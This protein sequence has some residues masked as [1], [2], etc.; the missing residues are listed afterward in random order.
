MVQD[1]FAGV[2]YCRGLF[3]QYRLIKK[4]MKKITGPFVFLI[5]VG[6]GAAICAQCNI[7]TGLSGTI[8]NSSGTES[9]S[10]SV[11][12]SGNCST[13]SHGSITLCA[14]A[15]P[16]NTGAPN[17]GPNVFYG[18]VMYTFSRPIKKVD[19][20]IAG[21]G[22]NQA[23]AFNESYS[24]DTNGSL[25]TLTVNPRNLNGLSVS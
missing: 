23:N 3:L 14:L 1:S 10:Y 24:I 17:V 11:T 8:Q 13:Q 18:S 2:F 4:S 20:F 15:W 12:F 7:I 21:Y 5:L 19:L 22:W 16:A 6:S 25:P 9:A